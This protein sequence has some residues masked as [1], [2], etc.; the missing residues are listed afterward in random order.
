M[1]YSLSLRP[2]A[3]AEIEAARDRYA[4]VEHDAPFLDELEFV[5]QAIRVMPMR[6]PIVHSTIHRALLRRYPFV[7]FF[8]IRPNTEQV[9]VLAVFPQRGDPAMW[10]KR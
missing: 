6:F 2:R 3:L 4:L 8:R 1:T 9:V 10:P 5:F 7:V